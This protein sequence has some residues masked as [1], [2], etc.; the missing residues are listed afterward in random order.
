MIEY[1]DV[2]AARARIAPHIVRTPLLRVPALDEA[3]GC[4][5]Y[6]K[7][8]G[9][10][11]IGAFKIRGAL[12]KALSL[13][14]EELGRGLVCASS[15]NHAQGVA[16]AAHKLGAQAVIVMPTNAN[17]VKLAGV[18][19]WGGQVELVGT[20]SSQ[21]EE[22]AAQL[23]RE[24]GMV[25]IHPYA[26]PFVAAGQ[27]TLALEVLED[28]PDA[29]LIAAPIGGGGLISGIA[30][31]VKGAAPQVRTVGVEPAGAPRYTRSRAEGRPVQ[32]ESVQ[33][34]ADGTRTDHANPDN[35]AVIQ[36]RVDELY[37]VEDRWIE[38]AMR[39]LMT[40]AKVIAEPSSVLPVAA[41]LC[42][43]LPVRPEDKAVFVL[44]G[45]NADPALLA[46]LLA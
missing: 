7:H 8:E 1:R 14:E 33:T 23:V 35:F 19:R 34:I 30:T 20:L 31:A 43:A 5:V 15:G 26:D 27:G 42:G 18:Q 36:A 39:L 3:L 28:L 12:N 22:R 38:E 9:F 4:Q 17:P 45:G 10:Q 16:Y 6:L 11:A 29:S 40:A 41:A 37:T 32:L 2:Q 13:S 25:E 21:R 24:Q 44:S 46:R